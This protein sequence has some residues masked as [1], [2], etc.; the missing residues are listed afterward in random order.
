MPKTERLPKGVEGFKLKG[1]Q[2]G[3]FTPFPDH[4]PPPPPTQW[5]TGKLRS[6]SGNKAR[7]F[8]EHQPL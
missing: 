4:G 7:P 6:H 1:K 3:D 8:P 5:F 2:A